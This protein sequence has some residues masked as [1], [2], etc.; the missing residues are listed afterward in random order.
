MTFALPSILEAILN[1][2][3]KSPGKSGSFRLPRGIKL[4]A[5]PSARA[6]R[7]TLGVCVLVG[8]LMEGGHN[9]SKYG[10]GDVSERDS[11]KVKE[12]T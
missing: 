3:I 2:E 8:K 4:E 9:C 1:L 11:V 12:D 5:Q 10:R 7:L 6:R